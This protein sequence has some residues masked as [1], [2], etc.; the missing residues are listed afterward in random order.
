MKLTYSKE[1]TVRMDDSIPGKRKVEHVLAAAA[2]VDSWKESHVEKDF[3][4]MLT[5][6]NGR[7]KASY[8]TARSLKLHKT[9]RIIKFKQKKIEVI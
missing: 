8:R 2:K 7:K 3:E 1:Y 5:N 9:G 4:P 6:K